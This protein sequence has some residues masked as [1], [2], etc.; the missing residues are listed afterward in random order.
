MQPL[1]IIV[2]GYITGIIWGRYLKTS[3]APVIFL[4]FF[5]GKIIFILVKNKSK[6]SFF[7]KQ[8]SKYKWYIL[9]ALILAFI[10]NIQI[11]NL[12][13]KFNTLYSNLQEVT[14]VRSY[15]K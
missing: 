12:E 7:N 10:S 8:I 9:F 4:L 6:F 13:N 1:V 11:M 2:V 3:I 5:T 15:N 14:A